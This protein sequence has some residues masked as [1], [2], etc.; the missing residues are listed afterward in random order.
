MFWKANHLIQ[1]I[2]EGGQ[3]KSI[4]VYFKFS[5]RKI[6]ASTII[7]NLAVAITIPIETFLLVERLFCLQRKIGKL[8][9]NST[10]WY[11]AS[12]PSLKIWFLVL[13][14]VFKL[15]DSFCI[16]NWW[17]RF[18]CNQMSILFPELRTENVNSTIYFECTLN[19]RV[20]QDRWVCM[21]GN[22]S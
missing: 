8:S 17:G 19:K 21:W 16:A 9:S 11:N 18:L 2:W 12:L 4:K 7:W 1:V 5:W 14:T 20:Q 3:F 15:A 6:T 13:N 22:A 10:T